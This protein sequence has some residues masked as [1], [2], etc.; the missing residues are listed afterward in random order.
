LK[1]YKTDIVFNK[2]KKW[3]L[4]TVVFLLFTIGITS[5]SFS[6]PPEDPGCDPG[7]PTCP[8]DGGVSLL[9]A[10]GVGIGAKNALKKVK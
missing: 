7:D 3:S 2:Y 6:L 10:V 1:L 4:I 9:I 8:I 5:K